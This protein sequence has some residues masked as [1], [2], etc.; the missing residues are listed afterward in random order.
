MRPTDDQLLG[1]V[2]ELIRTMPSLEV[3]QK[4]D[5]DTAPWEGRT[6]SILRAWS[7]WESGGCEYAVSELYSSDATAARKGYSRLRRLLYQARTALQVNTGRIS[8]VVGAGAVF[9]YFDE[10]RR[11][12]ETA[13][14]EVFFVDPYLEA[15]F[16]ARYLPHVAA[17]VPVRLLASKKMDMLLPAV[18]LFAQQTGADVKVRSSGS[19]HDR[20]LFIDKAQC[21]VSGASFKDG[22]KNAPAV[23]TQVQ[24][25]FAAMFQTY[26][27]IWA[28][29]KVERG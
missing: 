11:I 20:F 1:E 15:D 2:D 26:E 13:R 7:A 9:E 28:G 16:V 19:L 10:L 4:H 24:D 29:A 3:F 25:G 6:I 23:I 27:D 12:I 8:T 22:A 21:Y 5:S 17:N 14:V 18:S